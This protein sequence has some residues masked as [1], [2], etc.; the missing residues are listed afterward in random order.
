MGEHLW[1]LGEQLWAEQFQTV[2]FGWASG[3]GWASALERAA[4]LSEPSDFERAT[5]SGLGA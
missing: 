5:L 3:L 2:G 4:L 1:A